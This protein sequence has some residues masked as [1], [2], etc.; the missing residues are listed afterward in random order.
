MSV[1]GIERTHYKI[2]LDEH[3]PKN[4]AA[5]NER[6]YEMAAVAPQQRQCDFGSFAPARAS[7]EAATS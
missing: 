6:F 5:A 4:R 1:N 3:L 2:S 7:V